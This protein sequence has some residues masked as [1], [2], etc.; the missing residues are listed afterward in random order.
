MQAR[1]PLLDPDL[2]QLTLGQ[3]PG[4]SF[5]QH[6]SRPLLRQAMAG[7]L[8]DQVRLRPRKAWFDSLIVAC[9]AADEPVIR[10]LLT[11]PGAETRAF[12]QPER[13]TLALDTLA[14]A[15]GVPRFRAMHLIWRALTLE[16]WLRLQDDPDGSTLPQPGEITAPALELRPVTVTANIGGQREGSYLFPS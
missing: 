16:C 3:P 11:A 2:V 4:A 14:S 7:L 15:R 1:L 5:D 9:I 12:L 13:I 6:L 10:R 8:P